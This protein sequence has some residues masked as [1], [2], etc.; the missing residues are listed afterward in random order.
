MGGAFVLSPA[1]VAYV[2]HSGLK[3]AATY[4]SMESAGYTLREQI[5]WVKNIF[6]LSWAE[7]HWRHELCVYAVRASDIGKGGVLWQGGRGQHTVWSINAVQAQNAPIH[8]YYG[9]THPTQK[10]VECF[11][12]PMRNHDA[13]VVIDMFVGSGTVYIA[14]ERVGRAALG[15]ELLPEYCDMAL[16]RWEAYTGKTA[17]LAERV[18]GGGSAGDAAAQAR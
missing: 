13:R 11:A 18:D 8:D 10:P 7:Y 6:S 9:S 17:R 3:L 12:R 2:W 16:A 15:L 1:P 5:V 4:S 14:A